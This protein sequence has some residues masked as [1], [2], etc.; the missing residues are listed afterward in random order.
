MFDQ[1]LVSF[2]AEA[3]RTVEESLIVFRNDRPM[4][5]TVHGGTSATPKR[6]PEAFELVQLS[7][8]A[9]LEDGAQFRNA[10]LGHSHALAPDEAADADGVAVG[11][12]LG[13]PA[14]Q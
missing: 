3:V 9:A 1:A 6:R 8:I 12:T 5:D 2:G 11:K 14:R 13:A 10:G 7:R 4:R